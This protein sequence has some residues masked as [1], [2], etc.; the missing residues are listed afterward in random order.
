[1][2]KN[3][4]LCNIFLHEHDDL[5][6]CIWCHFMMIWSDYE[7]ILRVFKILQE[8]NSLPS[9]NFCTGKS[10]FK[11]DFGQNFFNF[12]PIFNS[13]TTHFRTN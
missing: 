7:R 12:Q 11:F 3:F 4:H 5:I 8:N 1:M 9:M 6:S 2:I 13:L 10:L